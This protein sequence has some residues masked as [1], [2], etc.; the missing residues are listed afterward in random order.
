[1]SIDNN[2]DCN[3]TDH[4]KFLRLMYAGLNKLEEDRLNDEEKWPHR[5]RLPREDEDLVSG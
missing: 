1:M 2:K 5:D 3:D 4:I